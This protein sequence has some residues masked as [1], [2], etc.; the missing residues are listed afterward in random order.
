MLIRLVT[1]YS[2]QPTLPGTRCSS[3]ATQQPL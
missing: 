2:S 1:Q 3:I